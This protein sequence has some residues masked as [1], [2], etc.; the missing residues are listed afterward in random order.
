MGGKSISFAVIVASIL[1]MIGMIV[2]FLAPSNAGAEFYSY[3]DSNG[4]THFVDDLS[5]IPKEFRNRK[6]VRKDAYDDL[7]AD[8]RAL[9]L[10]KEQEK[11]S[12]ERRHESEQQEQAR[13]RRAEE[14]RKAAEERLTTKVIISGRQVF[15]PV[16]LG[17]GSMETDVML[18]LDTG[19]SS[20][21]ITP[22]VAE[23]LKIM[24]AEK[25]RIGVVGGRFINAGRVV[26]SHMEVGPIKKTDQ[27]AVIV[28]KHPG[29]Y[30]DGLLGMSFLGG[31]KYTIDFDKQTINWIP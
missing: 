22:E 2:T 27:E 17:N 8:E 15:V 10:G 23:R 12:A 5:N 21:V 3:E 20:S 13:K 30:G 6:Q 11:R 31:L 19:A 9:L 4:T 16:K 26:L 24:E 7:T 29:E 28:K 1:V 14:E 18:L 25:V